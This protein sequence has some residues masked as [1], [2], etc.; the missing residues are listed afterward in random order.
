MKNK[1]KKQLFEERIL[2]WYQ[3]IFAYILLSVSDRDVAEDLTQ[4]VFMRAYEKL[5]QLKK[6]ES[7]KAWLQ[8]I[9]ANEVRAWY[10]ERKKHAHVISMNE[11][12]EKGSGGFSNDIRD[13][14]LFE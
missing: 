7:A 2:P 1:K 9:A 13:I 8:T 10:I 14:R 4:N 11:L 3:T 6:A 12:T 5:H